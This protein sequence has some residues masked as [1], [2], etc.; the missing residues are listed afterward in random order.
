MSRPLMPPAF[1]LH[2][3][4]SGTS[5]EAATAQAAA[6]VPEGAVF[7]AERTD[8]FDLT[9][10]FH[11]DPPAA[12]AL[13]AVHVV[14]VALGDAV[15]ALAPPVLALHLGWP[16]RV[17]VNGALAGGLRARWTPDGAPDPWLAVQVELAVTPRSQAPGR[18]AWRT[19]LHDEGCGEIDTVALAEAL[20]RHLLNWLHVWDEDGFAPVRAAWHARAE[21]YRA[22][23]RWE[24]PGLA[25]AGQGLELDDQGDLVVAT[26]DGVR[27]VPLAGAL[28]A[29]TWSLE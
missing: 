2:V 28:A 19:T 5:L 14:A 22:P 3:V 26:E 12:A 9:L 18:T 20:G 8:R 11:T 27:H 23:F 10:V 6:G 13:P 25:L 7:W 15:G 29:P 17:L 1:R 24:L 4:T 21:G 16:D